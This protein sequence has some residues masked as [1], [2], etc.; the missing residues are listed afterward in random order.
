MGE[1]WYSEVT[2]LLRE[3]SAM[4][5]R[6][7]P[8]HQ[9]PSGTLVEGISVGPLRDEGGMG[10]LGSNKGGVEVRRGDGIE[11]EGVR[12]GEDVV[13]IVG[14]S[15]MVQAVGK[16]IGVIGRPGL[17]EKTDIVIAEGENVAGK[18]AVDFLGAA[19]VLKVL[20]VSK[21]VDNKL[22]F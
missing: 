13:I 3:L 17:V 18:A 1:S 10:S 9:E 22:S 2:P 4:T 16:G 8:F 5:T 21:D 12:E 20:V 15:V 11:E 6:Q 14:T 19:I 7:E